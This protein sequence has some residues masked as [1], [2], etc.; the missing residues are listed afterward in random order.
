MGTLS[1][2]TEHG[3]TTFWVSLRAALSHTRFP[4]THR[5]SLYRSSL[6][7]TVIC[8]R[9]LFG[10]NTVLPHYESHTVNLTHCIVHTER[11]LLCQPR[12]CSFGL[13]KSVRGAL[14]LP[15]RRRRSH[16]PPP[17]S[18]PQTLP[19]SAAACTLQR[20]CRSP[21][22]CRVGRRQE[23]VR[24][25]G[26]AEAVSGDVMEQGDACRRARATAGDLIG[27]WARVRCAPATATRPLA[28]DFGSP[29]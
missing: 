22:V 8:A 27:C 15:V 7:G 6:V 28:F 21:V 4:P 10:D 12:P 25:L 17:P 20:A 9:Q 24:G 11:T 2:P 26:W 23:R 19:P 16:T 14:M 3:L 1:V 5:S 29:M 18:S 13:N